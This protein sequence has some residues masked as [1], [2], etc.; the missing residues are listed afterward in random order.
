VLSISEEIIDPIVYIVRKLQ[1]RHLSRQC[2][3]P[4]R[5]KCLREVEREDVHVVAGRQHRAHGV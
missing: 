3:V 5:V 4:D 1:T 2:V